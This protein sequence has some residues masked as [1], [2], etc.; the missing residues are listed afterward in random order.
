MS[1]LIDSKTFSRPRFNV[2]FNRKL[3]NLPGVHH[4]PVYAVYTVYDSAAMRSRDKHAPSFHGNT[5]DKL[6]ST[7][8]ITRI[9]DQRRSSEPCKRRWKRLQRESF[10]WTQQTQVR[11]DRSL[12]LSEEHLLF[13]CSEELNHTN[14][15]DSVCGV[16]PHKG[17]TR[18][19]CS[20]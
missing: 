8:V 15:D 13:A 19:P 12:K 9:R 18:N 3:A 7:D 17:H 4:R 2:M 5:S 16:P 1:S 14:M 6:T 11:A 20:C 10:S